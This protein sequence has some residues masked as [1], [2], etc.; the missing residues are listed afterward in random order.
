MIL[1]NGYKVSVKSIEYILTIYI[2]LNLPNQSYKKFRLKVEDVQRNVLTNF[3][4]I[5]VT[6][7][8]L[9][10][11]VR[12]W[13]TLI[14]AHIHVKTTNNFTLRMFCIRFTKKRD[15]QV[16]RTCCAQSIQIREVK[17]CYSFSTFSYYLMLFVCVRLF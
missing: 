14:E 1:A 6:T 9:R 3:C 2:N 4:G 15:K 17:L 16:K 10:S 11:L 7:D 12:K 5:D 8:Q 13:E